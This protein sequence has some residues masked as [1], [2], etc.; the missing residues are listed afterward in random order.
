[1]LI[2]KRPDGYFLRGRPHNSYDCPAIILNILVKIARGIT[3]PAYNCPTDK[4]S[5]NFCPLNSFK[6]KLES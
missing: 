5:C 3:L 6:K 4:V 2:I 1:M